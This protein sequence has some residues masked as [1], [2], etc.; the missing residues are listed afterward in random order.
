MIRLNPAINSFYKNLIHNFSK[1]YLIIILINNN[2]N[3][4][5]SKERDIDR[6]WRVVAVKSV[7]SATLI[8]LDGLLH[9]NV[10]LMAT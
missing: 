2:R 8:R 6:K 1:H 3:V 10:A 7:H 4:M 5:H 9:G